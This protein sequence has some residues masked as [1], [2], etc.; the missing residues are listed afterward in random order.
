MF[1][2]KKN[3]SLNFF[4]SMESETKQLK[5]S[6]RMKTKEINIF[7]VDVFHIQLIIRSYTANSVTFS[8]RYNKFFINQDGRISASFL[9]CIFVYQKQVESC[10]H[11]RE[12]NP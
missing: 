2:D 9:L 5:A 10:V 6:K 1:C 8:W 3:I 4:L 12:S 11:K 7:N